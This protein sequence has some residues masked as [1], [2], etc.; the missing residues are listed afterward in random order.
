[1]NLGDT[2]RALAT[3]EAVAGALRA[4]LNTLVADAYTRDGVV[5]TMRAPGLTVVPSLTHPKVLIV[6]EPAFTAYV[7]AR[8]PTEVVTTTSIRPA[9]LRQFLGTLADAGDPPTDDEGTVIPGLV[10]RAGGLLT[11]VSVRPDPALRAELDAVAEQVTTG[12]TPFALP[13][14]GPEA[15]DAG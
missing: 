11:S 15:L 14:T 5:S 12:T 6:D 1:M 2:A 10:W 4:R 7:T 8:W 3:V 13:T 9:W